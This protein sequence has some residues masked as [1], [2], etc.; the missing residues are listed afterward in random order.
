MGRLDVST[1]ACGIVSRCR[2]QAGQSGPLSKC[3]RER[4]WV[5]H[6]FCAAVVEVEPENRRQLDDLVGKFRSEIFA[7]EPVSKPLYRD[8][9][10]FV[11][12]AQRP[13]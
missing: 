8:A 12:P 3:L 9:E 10:G 2:D 5:G 1:G 11:C 6:D 13:E 7:L 4:Q